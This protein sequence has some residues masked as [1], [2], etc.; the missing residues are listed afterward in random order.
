MAHDIFKTIKARITKSYNE[1]AKLKA[2][3]STS[4]IFILAGKRLT[5]DEI[6]ACY[7]SVEAF[8]E[9]DELKAVGK[10]INDDIY[11]DLDE[12]AKERYVLNAANLYSE[13]KKEVL[14][15]RKNA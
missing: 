3:R 5:A 11:N 8:T 7:Y 15:H 13:L 2:I 12:E 4:G 10:L 9:E 1:N 14:R 6:A